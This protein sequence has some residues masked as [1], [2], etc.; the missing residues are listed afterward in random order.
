VVS[1]G[2]PEH[3]GPLLRQALERAQLCS[4]DPLCSEHDPRADSSIHSACERGNR[5][6][7]RATISAT[8]ARDD[9]SYFPVM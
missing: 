6:L 2:E 4:S 1:L 5:Y 3:F 9:V 8:L 7:D